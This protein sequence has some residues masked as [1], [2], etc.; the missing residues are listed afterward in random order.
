M[1]RQ[2]GRVHLHASKYLLTWSQC[3]GESKEAIMDHLKTFD[4]KYGVVCQERHQDQSIHYHAVVILKKALNTHG[5]VFTI[6]DHIAN[7]QSLRSKRDVANA[8]SYVKKDGDF[9]EYGER[10]EEV[11]RRTK[12]EKVELV[13]TL[14]DKEIA[15]SGVFSFSELRNVQHV[16]NMALGNPWPKF[17]KR[18]VYWF[19]G[20]TGSGKTRTAVDSAENL[21]GDNYVILS[22]NLNTFFTGYTNEKGVIFDDLRPG[23][24]KFETLL[25]VL[26]GYKCMV[27]IKGSQAPW[28]AEHIWITAPTQPCDMYVNRETGQVWDNIDQLLRRIDHLIEFPIDETEELE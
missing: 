19:Y 2:T 16:R 26:D 13:K 1:L 3:P 22:G 18:E 28:L 20:S 15:E 4:L 12:K 10:P 6:R 23:S 24:I 7:I 9:I 17:K 25:R 14:T 27:N 21:F 5:N 11:E 8:T